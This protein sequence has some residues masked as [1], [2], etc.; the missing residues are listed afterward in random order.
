VPEGDVTALA[1]ALR[2]LLQDDELRQE[3]ARKGREHVKDRYTQKQVAAE[4]VA[5][6]RAM[7]ADAS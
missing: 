3:L 7:M 2:R 6:Y 4:T 1:H 5:V